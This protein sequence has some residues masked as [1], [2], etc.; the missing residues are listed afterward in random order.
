MTWSEH[1]SAMVPV[2][3]ARVAIVAPQRALRETLVRLADAGCVDIDR[4]DDAARD[5]PGSAARRLRRRPPAPEPAAALSPVPPDLDLLD[6]EGRLD[7][8]TGEARLE[9]YLG[10]AVRHGT[11]AA[12]AGWCPAAEVE[13]LAGDLAGLGC[14][15]LPLPAPRGTQPPTLLRST[16][17]VHRA[18]SPLMDTYGTAPYADADLTWPAGLV[19]V[20]MFGVMFGD[21]GHGALLLLAALLLR[22]GRPRRLA[23]WRPLWPFVAAAGVASVL[24]GAAYGEFFGPTG[25]LPPLWVNPLAQPERLLAGAL[26]FGGVLLALSYAAGTVN[27][28]REGGA[29]YALYA[30]SGVAGA[31]VFAGLV[32]L[33]G[34]LLTHR[35]AVAVAGALVV[36]AG[37]AGAAAGLYSA[38]PRGL[39]GAAQTGIQLFDT[40]VRL[41]S[42]VFSFARLAAFG[43]THA[44]LGQVVWRGTVA[45]AHRGAGG[46]AAG[47]ALFV[48]GNAFSFALEALIAAVQALRLEFYELFSR[49]FE[50]QGRPFRPWRLPVRRPAAPRTEVTT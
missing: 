19:Y 46:V 31:A 32:V 22:T 4:I 30:V 42:N 23:S 38:S 44:A 3:M 20:A 5:V 24:A 10:S 34:G 41:G 14:A 49:V 47:A 21:A 8:L 12:L 27:R 1:S 7:L 2:R 15:V 36:A 28:W 9:E 50:A 39:G 11:V 45:L 18:F 33:A 48:L 29:S 6:R 40:L 37:V 35:P 26:G 17:A 43:L 16:G 25:V 13:R